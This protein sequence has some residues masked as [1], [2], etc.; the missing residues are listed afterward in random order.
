MDLRDRKELSFHLAGTGTEM[1]KLE[2]AIGT[3][4]DASINYVG[5]LSDMPG[6]YREM[7]L[8][9]I[10]SHFEPMGMV[11]VEAMAC[12]TPVLAADVPGL[13]EVVQ[14][15]VNGWTYTGRSAGDLSRAITA[16]LENDPAERAVVIDRGIKDARRY[17]LQE[18]SERPGVR[19]SL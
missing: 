13:N 9:V 3:Q 18:F 12:G 14:H 4:E 8:L 11:A 16:L 10:P 1:K 15:Q 7:D 17:S 6:F 5:Y 2:R 19:G